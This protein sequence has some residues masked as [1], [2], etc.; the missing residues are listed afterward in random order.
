MTSS[1]LRGQTFAAERVLTG[2]YWTPSPPLGPCKVKHDP[3]YPTCVDSFDDFQV[4]NAI[5][6]THVS[7]SIYFLED[8]IL[9]IDYVFILV[10]DSIDGNS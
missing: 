1:V 5:P 2:R 4:K 10:L 6:Y 3:F 7:K 9:Y 8:F